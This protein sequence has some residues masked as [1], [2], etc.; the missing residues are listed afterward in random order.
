MAIRLVVFDV[1]GTTWDDRGVVRTALHDAIATVGPDLKPA[2]IAGVQGLAQPMAIRMLLEGHGREDLFPRVP[3]ILDAFTAQLTDHITRSGP[4]DPIPGIP[5]MFGE[6]RAANV[7]VA[8]CTGFS[9]H[10]LDLLLER[11]GWVGPHSPVDATVASDEVQRGRPWPD[12]IDRLR[13]QLGVPDPGD[14]A[15]V[16]DTP[17]DLQ[18]GTVARC[19]LVIGVCTGGHTRDALSHHPHDAILESAADVASLVASHAR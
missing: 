16:G 2:A 6:L 18:E 14:V 12:M 15:K 7:H 19:G 3:E 17:V 5:A 4:V 13:E 9:R 11:L 1:A 10:V 8:L